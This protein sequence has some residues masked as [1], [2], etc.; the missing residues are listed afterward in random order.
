VGEESFMVVRVVFGAMWLKRPV[1]LAISEL[2]QGEH[3]TSNIEL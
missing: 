1:W 3:R 2:W